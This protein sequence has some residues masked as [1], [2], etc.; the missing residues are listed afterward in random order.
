MWDGTM[1]AGQRYFIASVRFADELFTAGYYCEAYD[2]YS[3][4]ASIGQLDGTALSNQSQA[5]SNC[6]PPTAVITEPPPATEPS[7]TEPPTE[8]PPTEPPPTP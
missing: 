8:P 5:Y 4:A 7:P 1:T 6:F 3:A 2:Q